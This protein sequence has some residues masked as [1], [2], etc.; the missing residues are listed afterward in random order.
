MLKTMSFW[1]ATGEAEQL[2]V[3]KTVFS[4]VLLVNIRNNGNRY[5]IGLVE[6]L[7]PVVV[8]INVNSVTALRTAMGT[9]YATMC[10]YN[11]Q[12]KL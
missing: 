8:M 5:S 11:R 10:C 9:R 6:S 7:F 3:T 12:M 4:S 1:M 2:A